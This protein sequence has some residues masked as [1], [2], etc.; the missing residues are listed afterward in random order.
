MP[1]FGGSSLEFVTPNLEAMG[2][3]HRIGSFFFFYTIIIISW[4]SF[5]E[6]R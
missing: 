3:L 1:Y 6:I 4:G 2:F 5:Q